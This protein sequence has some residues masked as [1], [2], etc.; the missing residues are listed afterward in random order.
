M[1][2]MLVAVLFAFL[3]IT[4]FGSWVVDKDVHKSDTALGLKDADI[5]L[6]LEVITRIQENSLF[7]SPSVTREN[8]VQDTLKAYLAAKD[9]F[10]DYLT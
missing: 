4:S 3:L 6:Y 7:L 8:I 9:R 2:N 5:L 10:S 1:K